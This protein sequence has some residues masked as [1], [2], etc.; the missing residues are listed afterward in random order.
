[1]SVG[2]A[3]ARF[4]IHVIFFLHSHNHRDISGWI[5]H[6]A[7]GLRHIKAQVNWRMHF[8]RLAGVLSTVEQK[9]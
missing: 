5:A 3:L 1:M 8:L 7:P 2:P 6:I 4:N 9:D